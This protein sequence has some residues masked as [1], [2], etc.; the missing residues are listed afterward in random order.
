MAGQH[1]GAACAG[2]AVSRSGKGRDTRRCMSVGSA[3]SRTP[4]ADARTRRAKRPDSGASKQETRRRPALRRLQCY[5]RCNYCYLIAT[6][7]EPDEAIARR[8][9]TDRSST[10]IVRHLATP[11]PGG[12]NITDLGASIVG[13]R[14]NAIAVALSRPA[15]DETRPSGAGRTQIAGAER[16]S[17]VRPGVRGGKTGRS[18]LDRPAARE[19]RCLPRG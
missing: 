7:N 12:A 6:D 8:R 10:E 11:S 2:D 9:Y 13:L 14:H 1:A 18:L 16:I 19:W 17:G 3:P 4:D 5:S 15:H